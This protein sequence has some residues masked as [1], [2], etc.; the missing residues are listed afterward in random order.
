V[1]SS[2]AVAKGQQ[3]ATSRT[4][5]RSPLRPGDY[6]SL[7]VNRRVVAQ[8]GGSPLVELSL[9]LQNAPVPERR[10]AADGVL[11][12]RTPE[13]V[14]LVFGQAKITSTQLQSAVLLK[15]SF[16]AAR[17]FLATCVDFTPRLRK[18]VEANAVHKSAPLQISG[19]EPS[20]V[21]TMTTNMVAAV[22]MGREACLDFY[23]ASPFAFRALGNDGT[24]LAVDP[25]LRV[26]LATGLLL[27]MVE[28]LEALKA[29][30]PEAVKQENG[31]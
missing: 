30:L 22:Y 8:P 13:N 7:P 10:Y 24:Q 17:S 28:Q 1:I 12:V 5:T 31:Q 14:H 2:P 27:S 9:D 26:E 20:Q 4:M 11:A 16:D 3:G 15:F 21:V 18:F 29:D 25:L 23:N 19:E 6:G